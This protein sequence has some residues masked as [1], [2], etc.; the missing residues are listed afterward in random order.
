MNAKVGLKVDLPG[1]DQIGYLTYEPDAFTG[2][3]VHKINVETGYSRN[4]MQLGG[5][6]DKRIVG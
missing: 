4:L 2:A 6:D 5:S 1:L 3:G